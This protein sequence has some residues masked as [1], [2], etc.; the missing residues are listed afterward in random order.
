[1]W[2]LD[3]QGRALESLKACHSNSSL[4]A[5]YTADFMTGHVHP[6]TAT[7]VEADQTLQSCVTDLTITV[8]KEHFTECQLDVRCQQ[9]LYML[10]AA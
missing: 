5:A 7:A 10:Q 9:V 1:M 3:H 2:L 6:G 4:V 8:N